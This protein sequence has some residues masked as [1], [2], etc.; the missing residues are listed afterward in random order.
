[1]PKRCFEIESNGCLTLLAIA[2]VYL[3]I[4]EAWDS[5]YKYMTNDVYHNT[6]ITFLI[7]L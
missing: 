2:Q 3:Q 6:K 5:M 7:F 1:M 4:F